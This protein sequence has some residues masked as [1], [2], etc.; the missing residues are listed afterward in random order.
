MFSELHKL[1]KYNWFTFKFT[2]RFIPK[3]PNVRFDNQRYDIQSAEYLNKNKEWVKMKY[4]PKISIPKKFHG[5]AK[6][7]TK[8]YNYYYSM[9]L[10]YDTQL[11]KIYTFE[12]YEEE[13]NKRNNSS[14]ER[15]EEA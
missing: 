4:N 2:F 13:K 1:A 9:K 12:E 14:S 11:D 7:E 3:E 15:L 10:I 6:Y 5:L 8:E